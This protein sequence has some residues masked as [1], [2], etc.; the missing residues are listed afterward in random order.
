MRA[1]TQDRVAHAYLFC[2]PSGIGKYTTGVA[3]AA[4]LNCLNAPGQ[5]CGQCNSCQKIATSIHPDV[6]TLERQGSTKIIPIE[7]IR[8][9]VI[10]QMGHPPHEGAA[11]VILIEEANSLPD[12]SA[13]ALL[14]TLEEPPRRT[15]FVLCTAA[16]EELL[17]TIR[18]R[19][20]RINFAPLPPE[21]RAALA[22]DQEGSEQIAEIADS[23]YRIAASRGIEELHQAAAAATGDRATLGSAMEALAH[24]YY[25]EA[26]AAAIAG[27]LDHATAASRCA[28]LA[29]DTQR[30]L[31]GNA[32]PLLATESML[33]QLRQTRLTT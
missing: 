17:P 6:Q 10:P 15:H 21:M 33:Q 28:R 5:G 16:P 25:Q 29:L 7:T 11:R 26:R 19:C 30:A 27:E 24:R 22:D 23:L 9:Q 12:A 18:S 20:Q 14:K 32:H 8:N 4:A 13:N 3:L 1:L 31:T 2:G